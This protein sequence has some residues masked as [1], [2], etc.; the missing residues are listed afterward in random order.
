MA[1]AVTVAFGANSLQFQAE[2]RRMESMAAASGRRMASGGHGHMAGGTGMIRETAVIGREIAMGRG[3]GRI[4]GSLTLLAQYVNTSTRNAQKGSSAARDL[5]DAY[6][7]V[8]Y[9][10]RM[11]SIAAM[12]KAEASAAAAKIDG[13]A[14]AE[15]IST[16]TAEKAAQNQ[17]A[18]AALKSAQDV[19]AAARLKANAAKD[20]FDAS[21]KKA[22]APGGLTIASMDQMMADR[23]AMKSAAAEAEAEAVKAEA[24]AASA[25][26]TQAKTEAELQS[27]IAAE[28]NATATMQAAAADAAEANMEANGATAL[29]AKAAAAAS[30]ADAEEGL[31]AATASAS[32]SMG[33]AMA[34]FALAVVIIAELYVVVKGLSE[35]LSKAANAQ[36]EAAK[37]ANEHKLAIWEE[38]EATEK[39]KDATEKTVEAIKKMNVAKD[40]QVD[41]A[42]QAT[43]A[44]NAETEAREK[45]YDARVKTKMLEIGIAEKLGQI[46]TLEAINQKAAIESQAVADKSAAEQA[47]LNRAAKIANDASLVAMAEK[48][49]AQEKAQA[50]SDVINSS[51]EGKKRA[52]ALAQ[53]EKD[54]AASKSE[55]EQAKKD[56]IEFN[57]GGSNTLWSSSLKARMEGFA[58]VK[59]KAAA[60]QETAEAK[61]NAASSAEIR[62]NS[63]KRFMKPDETVAAEAMR[64][65][66]EK[67]DAA[68]SLG[69]TATAAYTAANLHATYS[70]H[71]VA[72]EQNN[73]ELQREQEILNSFHVGKGYQLNSQQQAGAYAATPPEFKQMVNLLQSVANNTSH[74]NP[75]SA[76]APGTRLPQFGARP[77]RN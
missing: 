38:I 24:S 54:L 2:L 69:L 16:L 6:G 68:T 31:A 60:L 58:G 39:L 52:E 75:P 5:A 21:Y 22:Q 46:N 49:K 50:A 56:Q 18:Q 62:V 26:A 63:L 48:N 67:T 37:W 40:H 14:S 73:I 13:D 10:A 23:A 7:Q 77:T 34:F 12:K 25:A 76:P 1:T 51:P 65:A 57:N 33:T 36:M 11:A 35:I 45:L 28:N 41:L 70:G 64:V 44:S 29:E 19:A 66:Q 71:Q 59:D 8:A 9:K 20:A 61:A 42:R 55:A 53:A 4:L 32:G 47:K 74:L 3:M 72:A 43:E 17:V 15:F 27:A 30:A